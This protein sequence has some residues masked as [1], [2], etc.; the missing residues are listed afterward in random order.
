MEMLLGTECAFGP[1]SCQ[2]M[3]DVSEF[4]KGRNQILT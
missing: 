2:T 1:M 4:K 3:K